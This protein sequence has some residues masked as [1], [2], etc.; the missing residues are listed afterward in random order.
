MIA[1]IPL[2]DINLRQVALGMEVQLLADKIY[3][4]GVVQNP[5]NWHY[6]I[7]SYFNEDVHVRIDD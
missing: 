3:S 6:V 7:I 5:A 4:L 1:Q 2:G